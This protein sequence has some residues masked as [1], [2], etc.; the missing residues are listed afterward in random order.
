[1]KNKFEQLCEKVS[2]D[3]D[4]GVLLHGKEKGSG[5]FE[6][7]GNLHIHHRGVRVSF[8]VG[9]GQSASGAEQ[10]ARTRKVLT[11]LGMESK[12]TDRVL[13]EEVEE[14]DEDCDNCNCP[15]HRW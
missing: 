12:I 2:E 15:C 7:D 14:T 13:V 6:D 9:N 5:C 10:N 11:A 3:L 4:I 1:M 8:D